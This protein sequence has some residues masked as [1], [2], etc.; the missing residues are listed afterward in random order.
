[1]AGYKSYQGT[2]DELKTLFDPRRFKIV[3]EDCFGVVFEATSIGIGIH[4]T[5]S[6]VEFYSLK[7]PDAI[8]HVTSS[9]PERITRLLQVYTDCHQRD[10]NHEGNLDGSNKKVQARRIEKPEPKKPTGPTVNEVI[11]KHLATG[12][13]K[14]EI[15]DVLCRTFPE[16][17]RKK[18]WDQ[19]SVNISIRKKK[20]RECQIAKQ[21]PAVG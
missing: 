6:S 7:Y 18:L 5:G 13:S 4:L 3:S 1:M 20:E 10:R 8:R 12:Q 2:L 21:Q 9:T 15:I 14:E 11:N 17:E 16:R 19:I